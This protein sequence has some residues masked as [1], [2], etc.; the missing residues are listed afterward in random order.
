MV[1]KIIIKNVNNNNNKSNN[2][3]ENSLQYKITQ[4]DQLN[5]TMQRRLN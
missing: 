1:I 2:L 3:D 5:I 4:C